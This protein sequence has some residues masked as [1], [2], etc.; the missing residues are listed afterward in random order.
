M[1]VFYTV[2]LP[3]LSEGTCDPHLS[4]TVPPAGLGMARVG[5]QAHLALTEG[6]RE[7]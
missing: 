7:G 1:V 3:G 5:T 6:T 4:D 2:T